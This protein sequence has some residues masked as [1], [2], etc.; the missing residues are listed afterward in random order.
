MEQERIAMTGDGLNKSLS[1]LLPTLEPDLS[2]LAVTPSGEIV[3]VSQIPAPTNV[4][5]KPTSVT[6]S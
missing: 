6:G 3:N 2:G 4:E 1:K 5:A